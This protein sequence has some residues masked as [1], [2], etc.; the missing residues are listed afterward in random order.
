MKKR[1]GPEFLAQLE[2]ILDAMRVAQETAVILRE[3]ITRAIA[4]G[5]H[6]PLRCSLAPSSIG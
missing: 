6:E 4:A 5:R 1:C 2:V 3:G